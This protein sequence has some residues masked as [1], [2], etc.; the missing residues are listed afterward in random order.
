MRGEGVDDTIRRIDTAARRYPYQHTYTVYPGPNSNT[1]TAWV[2]RHVPEL[3]LDLPPTAIGK[4]YLGD[5]L[6]S[7]TP[8]GPSTSFL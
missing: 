3:R 2:A 4:N 1:F 7:G 5:S 6:V 8:S